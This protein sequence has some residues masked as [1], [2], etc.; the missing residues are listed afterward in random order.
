MVFVEQEASVDY[1]LVANGGCRRVADSLLAREH[2]CPWDA[3][4]R[5]AS[6]LRVGSRMWCGE[7]S[8]P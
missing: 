8:E 4:D 2:S 7:L 5:V 6:P 1:A 3:T